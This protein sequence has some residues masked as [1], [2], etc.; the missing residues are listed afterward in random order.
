MGHLVAT[1]TRSSSTADAQEEVPGCGKM[2]AGTKGGK[3]REGVDKKPSDLKGK[4][5]GSRK[6]KAYSTQYSQEVYNPSTGQAGPCL[7]SEIRVVW[8]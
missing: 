4:R 3:N 7:A 2:Q 5:R 1:R 6:P 8:L